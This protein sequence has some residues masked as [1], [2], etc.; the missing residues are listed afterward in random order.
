MGSSP[1]ARG[2]LQEHLGRKD[3]RRIIPARAG[4]TTRPSLLMLKSPDHPRSRG[5]YARSARRLLVGTGSSPLARGLRVAGFNDRQCLGII[6]ARAGFTSVAAWSVTTLPDHPRSRGVYPPEDRR[7][8]RFR[9]SSPLARG[10][11]PHAPR[12]RRSPWIIPARAGFTP[13]PLRGRVRGRIIPAR[14]GFTESRPRRP[15]RM[16][17]HPRSRG[18]YIHSS[19]YGDEQ[20]GSSPLARGLLA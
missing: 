14:A 17:D 11:P 9:G 2:L 13:R 1:L 15:E 8:R 5:V 10:L 6:P 16:P 18:V 3:L 12:L 19:Y 7:G 4:F 20:F